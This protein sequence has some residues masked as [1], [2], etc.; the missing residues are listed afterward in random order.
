MKN[1]SSTFILILACLILNKTAFSAQDQTA[2]DSA[3]SISLSEDNASIAS[4]KLN[5]E[6]NENQQKQ[7]KEDV[8]KITTIDNT[9]DDQEEN[10]EVMIEEALSSDQKENQEIE[11]D[12][13]INQVQ[14]DNQT[15]L[16]KKDST[17]D[18]T[19]EI[20]NI[21]PEISLL[22]KDNTDASPIMHAEPSSDVSVAKN[23]DEKELQDQYLSKDEITELNKDRLFQKEFYNDTDKKYFP[24]VQAK[25]KLGYPRHILR[26]MVLVPLTQTPIMLTYFHMIGM[27]D[28]KPNFETNIA[29]GFRSLKS[30]FILGYYG[31]YDFRVTKHKNY[32]HQF[33]LGT[34]YLRDFFEARFN[35]YLPL[36]TKHFIGVDH[37]VKANYTATHTY[38]ESL[39][40]LTYEVV[41]PGFDIEVGGNLRKHEKLTGVFKAFFF[42]HS[43][44]KN[45]GG[46]Q[47]RA[48]YQIN[49]I[50]NLNI[51]GVYDNHR[52]FA[53]YFGVNF[54]WNFGYKQSLAL[55]KL[56]QKMTQMPI[57]DIDAVTT[58]DIDRNIVL[59]TNKEEGFN[60][61]I[62]DHP[63]SFGNAVYKNTD[64][65]NRNIPT[66]KKV[67]DLK[68]LNSKGRFV[69]IRNMTNTE[70]EKCEVS[71]FDA[72]NVAPNGTIF[73]CLQDKHDSRPQMLTL[74]HKTK[75]L[76]KISDT[77]RETLA[78]ELAQSNAHNLQQQQLAKVKHE[79]E[80]QKQKTKHETA[81]NKLIQTRQEESRKLIERANKLDADAAK[82]RQEAQAI[83]Q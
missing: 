54:K 31:F 6:T 26:P 40:D 68:T 33:T 58:T 16:P 64:Q 73:N 46:V 74:I 1:C 83:Q 67:K 71:T 24:E 39:G 21:N 23:D 2:N 81:M 72:K 69:G 52:K 57:R 41:R 27:V 56:E 38:S 49:K 45:I 76:Q 75:D 19:N 66:S 47:L 11:T 17:R 22:S 44:F 61:V 28:S 9:T 43:K 34:E 35:I 5:K 51:E 25:I 20:S 30:D 59:D 77:Y 55:S 18:D 29:F 15:K 37:F 13:A 78:K 42:Y 60:P 79:R 10:P 50:V 62:N 7:K 8:A 65:L 80:L 70:L 63:K 32:I 36:K 12:N 14:E 53:G 4:I 82:L 48:G 3:P